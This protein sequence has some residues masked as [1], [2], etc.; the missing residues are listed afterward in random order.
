MPDRPLPPGNRVPENV[1]WA[2]HDV[3]E[4]GVASWTPE[5]DGKG[6]ATQVWFH[7]TTTALPHPVTIR[8]KTARAVD[9]LVAMLRRHRNDVWPGEPNHYPE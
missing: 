5:R 6:P 2:I 9:E 1:T 7:L 4:Y 3:I 8:L